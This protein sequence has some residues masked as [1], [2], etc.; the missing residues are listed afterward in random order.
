[1]IF[2]TIG[3]LRALRANNYECSLTTKRD[4][5]KLIKVLWGPGVDITIIPEVP[6]LQLLPNHAVVFGGVTMRHLLEEEKKVVADINEVN[7]VVLELKLAGA[8]RDMR[9]PGFSLE[10]VSALAFMRGQGGWG[11]RS[12]WEQIKVILEEWSVLCFQ[13]ARGQ[14]CDLC[15]HQERPQDKPQDKTRL[16]YC[17][18]VGMQYL[19]L[20]KTYAIVTMKADDKNH[21]IY[22]P[23]NH[24]TTMQLAKFLPLIVDA[25]EKKGL[26][27]SLICII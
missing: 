8:M 26:P 4:S 27:C 24:T 9:D 6:P 5:R 25:E 18:K 2:Q 23:N 17:Y 12:I 16:P 19:D 1:M 3:C 10:V 21:I 15:R 11:Q 13:R 14:S 22:L 7:K 20:E